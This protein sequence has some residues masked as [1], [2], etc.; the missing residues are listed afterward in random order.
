MSRLQQLVNIQS[1]YFIYF[2][3]RIDSLFFSSYWY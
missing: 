1:E 2:L 3:T